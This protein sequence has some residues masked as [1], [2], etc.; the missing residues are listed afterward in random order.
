MVFNKKKV[1]CFSILNMRNI[2][3]DRQIHFT[4]PFHRTPF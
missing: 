1:A 4:I 2:A 3:Q